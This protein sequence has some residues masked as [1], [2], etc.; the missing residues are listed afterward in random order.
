MPDYTILD[1]MSAVEGD[2]RLTTIARVLETSPMLSQFQME[3]RPSGSSTFFMENALPNPDYQEFNATPPD[4]NGLPDDPITTHNKLMRVR[5]PID[6]ALAKRATRN[7]MSYIDRE[8]RKHVRAM[9]LNMKKFIIGRNNNSAQPRGLYSWVDFHRS[10]GVFKD[11]LSI[12]ATDGSTIAGVGSA[13]L[14]DRMS[15]LIDAVHTPDFFLSNRNVMNQVKNFVE[16]GAATEKFANKVNFTTV[17]TAPGVET[18]VITYE[19]IPWFPVDQ[20]SQLVEIMAFDEVVGTSGNT[21]SSILAIRSGEEA[22]TLIQEDAGGPEIT[23]FQESGKRVIEIE[24]LNNIE[25]RNER[26]VGR[27][28][29]IKAS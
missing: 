16:S 24:W 3:T 6:R 4:S 14:M 23:D 20:D 18:R 21:T 28:A 15:Q 10:A 22:V 7:G 1:V 29:G 2:K 25:V 19:G 9:S 8:V 12:F 5:I 11:Q 13:I 26:A 27:L 17:M